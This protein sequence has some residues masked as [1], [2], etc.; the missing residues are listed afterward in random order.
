MAVGAVVARILTQYSD[1]GSKA[2]QK[3]IA[4]LG[5][6]FDAFAKKTVRAFGVATAA[7]GAF[8]VKIGKDAVQAAI[9]DQK[10]QAL[11]ANSLRNTTGAT[12]AAIAS[13]EG[14]ISKLQLQV[15]VADDELRP[16]LS[17]LAAVT[18]DVSSAQKLLGTALDVSAFATVDLGA[19]TKA[20][21]KALQGNFKSLQ[22]LVPGLDAAAIK[23]KKFGE[24]LA[25]VE[26]ITSGA[27]ATRAGT[28]EFRLE[29]LRI[30]FGEILETLGYALLP[31][32][33][34]FA[35][36]IQ[37]DVLPQIERFIAA[38]KTGLVDGFKNAAEA[39]IKVAKAMIAIGFAIA[40]NIDDIILL[41]GI[42]ATM[43]AT[44]KVYAFAKAVAAVSLAFNGM[45]TA[46][47][48][49]AVASAAATGGAGIAGAAGVGAAAGIAG[50]AVIGGIAA[51]TYG[52]GQLDLPG[53]RKRAKR[54]AAEQEKR[55]SGY[56]G[57]PGASDIAG[58]TSNKIASSMPAVDNSMQ[59]YLK[60]LEKLQK[61]SD[62]LNGKK[63]KELT[64]EEKITAAIAKK[65]NVTV[66]TADIEAKATANAINAN[67]ARQAAIAKSS[68]TV[69]L[70]NQGNGSATGSP[71]S[72]G[73]N[74]VVNVNVNTPFIT[75]D[76]VVIEIENGLNT[77]QRRRGIGAGGG[78]FRGMVAE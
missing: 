1:K 9:A 6:N 18:G 3:D 30:R 10:S 72:S 68:P 14:Y 49:A 44:S 37:R 40:E 69:S 11:L 52:L 31:V 13:V 16:A 29:I 76:D 23:G 50:T 12:N 17:R 32:I 41:A 34:Q 47:A 60:F 4:K 64:I 35:D 51:L 27:A 7:V 45:K 61:A 58:F 36:T 26:K 48:G 20:I 67:L 63:G 59:K 56:A 28:L 39:G 55:L 19:A 38:N 8:A 65:Y 22:N 75:K 62:K 73:A 74:P 2:A 43:W 70:A 42:F 78:V 53:T 25:E 54:L 21:T 5:K 46:A 77:L 15:G 33:E 24:V 57:S 66:M 71:I